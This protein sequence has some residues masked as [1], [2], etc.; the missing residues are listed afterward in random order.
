MGRK[1]KNPGYDSDR[2]FKE[3]VDMVTEFYQTQ[4]ALGENQSLR[5]VADEFNTTILKVR[6]VLI[7]AGVFQSDA[8][9]RVQ[10]LF[11]DR[12]TIPEIQAEMQLSRA[13]VYSYLP[14][15][16]T[17]YNAK[18]L[19]ANAQRLQIYRERKRAVFAFQNAV[20]DSLL[21]EHIIWDVISAFAN[22]PFYTS[23]GMKFSYTV[24][25]GE[26]Q[27]NRKKK[28]ITKATVLLFIDR[29]VEMKDAGE[30]ITGP[31]KVG[32]FGASYLYPI[33]MR[34]GM[35]EEWDSV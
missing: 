27:V 29:V 5:S 31:K 14:Y 12:K 1:K 20:K 16:K 21:T 25:G 13:S 4:T 6:K 34:I 35:F 32:T 2:I 26:I 28:T 23:R 17:I 7:T 10:Q 15:M 18:E 11:S 24:H 8:S 30:K 9:E 22:Y 3:Y 19:S 33:F